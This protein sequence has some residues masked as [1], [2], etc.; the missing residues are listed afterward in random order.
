MKFSTVTPEEKRG[1]FRKSAAKTE[2]E[3]A[4]AAET[5]E[6]KP[7]KKTAAKKPAAK[8]P[9]AKKAAPKKTKSEE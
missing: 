6:A 7:A 3:A 8:K 9:A 1:G 4:P 5:A 2:G